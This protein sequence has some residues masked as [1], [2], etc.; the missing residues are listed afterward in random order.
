VIAVQGRLDYAATFA[1]ARGGVLLAILLTMG[2]VSP[3]RFDLVIR[4]ARIV[5]GDGRVSAR[6]TICILAGRIVRIEGP[7]PASVLQAG[8]VIDAGGRTVI[9]G[10]IDAH[11]HVEP[12]TLPLF[13]KYGITT[14]R[15]VHNRPDYILPLAA[16]ESPSQPRIIAAGAMIDGPGSFW[17]DAIVVSDFVAA[18]AAV[19]RQVEAGAGVIKVYTKLHPALMAVVVQEARARGVPVAAHL[20]KTTATEAAMIGVTS[21]EHLSGIAD[22]ASTE[23][24]RLYKAHDD[25]L[26]GWT[27]F[28]LEWPSLKP[29]ALDR[30][31]RALIERKVVLVPTLALHEAFSRL[32]DSDLRLDPALAD[33]PADVLSR[34]WDPADIMARAH[35]TPQVLAAFKRTLPVLQRFVKSYRQLGGRIV[36]GTDAPQ[37]FVVPG[38]SL[39]REL[40]LYVAGGL[41]PAAALKSATADAADLLGIADR[42]GTVDVGKDADLVL[43]DGDPLTDIRAT[44]RIVAVIRGGVVVH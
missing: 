25:F 15:D 5:H 2:A 29:A 13:L 28:E 37:Q 8:R 7:A 39:H 4:D 43:L 23:P 30:V 6:A 10:L 35:W 16:S 11:V 36:A 14:V 18:R 42:A 22:A 21:I 19:R 17:K 31:A 33:V 3:D 24:Q 1:M 44:R 9:P 40:E 12:W 27:V 38:S 26:G 20:G 34:S 41:T 32:A